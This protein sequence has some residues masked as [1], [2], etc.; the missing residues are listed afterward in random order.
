MLNYTGA[1]E[2]GD[3]FLI[4]SVYN[5]TT[6]QMRFGLVFRAKVDQINMTNSVF[7]KCSFYCSYFTLQIMVSVEFS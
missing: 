5:Y 1:I 7:K 2:T 6:V 4:T 3:G